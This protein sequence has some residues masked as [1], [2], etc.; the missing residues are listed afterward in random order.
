MKHNEGDL[1]VIAFLKKMDL[2]VKIKFNIF[3][4]MNFFYGDIG[5]L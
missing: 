5:E 2:V 4:S 3:R 1:K